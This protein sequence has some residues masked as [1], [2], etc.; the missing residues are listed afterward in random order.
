RGQGPRQSAALYATD[1]TLVRTL[2]AD[3]AGVHELWWDG[4]DDLGQPVPPA[5]YQV[6]AIT[7]DAR[8]VDDGAVGDNGNPL[9]AFNCD[10]ADRVV[11]LADG[12]FIVTTIYDEAG[13]SLR[14]YSSSGQPIFASNLA[15]KDFAAIALGGDDIYGVVG[16]EAKTRLVRIVLPG[17]RAR[18]ANG[19]DDYRLF[20]DHEK[21]GEIAGVA[22]AGGQAYIAASGMNVVRVIDLATGTHI[23]DWTLPA[24]ADLTA[25]GQGALWAI[26]GKDVVALDRSGHVTRRYGTGLE[27]PRYLA[28]RADRLAVVDRTAER[29]A[30]LDVANGR[31]LRTLGKPRP[32]GAWMPVGPETFSDPR[33]CAFLGDGRLV[34][35]EHDRVRILWPEAGRIS[36]DIVSDFMDV[37]VVHQPGRNTCTAGWASFTSIPSRARGPGSWKGRKA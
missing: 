22:V 29:L 20:A 28:A 11:S 36:A 16:T 19:A 6:R 31:V 34:L 1:G 26:S 17:D 33:G 25:D 23:A 12:G 14:R 32:P 3:A 4:L 8:L 21:P 35:T 13:Y 7:H 37:A 30:L 5:R 27:K 15:Q 24:V 18:M 10:N 9:G 2:V